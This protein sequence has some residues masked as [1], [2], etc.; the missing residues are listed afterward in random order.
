LDKSAFRK[1]MLDAGFLQE[2]D[3]VTGLAGR[4]AQGYRVVDRSEATVFPRPFK[5]GE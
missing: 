3:R 1:R 5:S 4:Q 2:V